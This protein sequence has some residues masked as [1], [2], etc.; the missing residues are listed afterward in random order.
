MTNLY[1]V[2]YK[3]CAYASIISFIIGFFTNSNTSFGAYLAGYSVLILGL[4]MILIVLF[5]KLFKTHPSESMFQI[6]YLIIST[7]GPFILMLGVV[8]FIFYLFIKYKNNVLEYDYLSTIIPI[9]LLS[10]MYIVL[11]NIDTDKFELTGKL[12]KIMVSI[13]YL[14]STLTLISSI[15]LYWKLKY[16]ITDG[17]VN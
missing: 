12:P 17:F 10:Q 8:M 11:N 13:L 4:L 15:L 2:V 3:S 16:Y 7:T 14:L 6:I 1:S 5:S 9:L